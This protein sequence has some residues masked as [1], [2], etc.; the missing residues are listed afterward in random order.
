MICLANALRVN[1]EK[2]SVISQLRDEINK[3]RKQHA[4]RECDLKHELDKLRTDASSKATDHTKTDQ[5]V[6]RQI[7]Q[8]MEKNETNANVIFYHIE[9]EIWKL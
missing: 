9:K 6:D 8:K 2:D 4:D 7:Q 1:L 5:E 3:L